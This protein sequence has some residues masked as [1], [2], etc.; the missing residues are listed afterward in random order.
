MTHEEIKREI[1]QK[2]EE[3]D[4][5]QLESIVGEPKANAEQKAAPGQTGLTPW[6]VWAV[7]RTGAVR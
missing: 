2:L 3:I 5:D 6:F 7:W 4:L 1:M